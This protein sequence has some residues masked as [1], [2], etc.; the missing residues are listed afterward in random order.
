MRALALLVLALAAGCRHYEPRP[1]DWTAELSRTATNRVSIASPD[2]AELIALMGNPDLNRLRLKAANSGKAARE[3]GWWDDPEL[4]VDLLRIVNPDEYPWLCGASLAFTLPLS[5]VPGL[6]ERAAAHYAAADAE[7]IRAAERDVGV[8]VRKSV[9]RIAALRE[10]VS[11][12][13]RYQDDE[14]ISNAF[15]RAARL[16]AAGE[17][18]PA[19]LSAARRRRHE[20]LH[21]CRT[22]ERELVAEE[23]GLLQLLGLR[24][25]TGVEL[26][27]G[28]PHA[29]H[30]VRDVRT[31]PLAVTQHPRVKEALLRLDGSEAA[32]Q[33]EIRRQYPD[34]KL[35]PAYSFEDGLDRFGLVAGLSLPLWNRNRKG[36]ATA[37][38][39]RDERRLEAI[40]V[41]R[42]LAHAE[43]AAAVCLA[44]LLDHPLPPPTGR[45]SAERLYAAGELGPLDYLAVRDEIVNQEIAEA[46]WRMEVC[47]AYEELKRYEVKEGK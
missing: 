12:L 41:W 40:E 44:N 9:V 16:E 38:G 2:A 37:E 23:S 4:D 10:K 32:L 6:E 22:A 19:E 3:T 33:A 47:L 1:V 35:G 26:A 17:V 18:A 45:A 46:E 34:L 43:A 39:E 8:D 11:L 24:P 27:P 42:S 25:G 21:A 7:A 31:N 15:A 5:G 30:A 29:D 20:R 28:D 13:R 14:A 36:I